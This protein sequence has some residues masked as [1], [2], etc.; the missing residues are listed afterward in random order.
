M[1]C[2]WCS[3]EVGERYVIR[4]VVTGHEDRLIEE[5]ICG[6]CKNCWDQRAAQI[7]AALAPKLFGKPPSDLTDLGQSE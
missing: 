7:M 5:V 4:L 1:N 2:P 6:G 3:A